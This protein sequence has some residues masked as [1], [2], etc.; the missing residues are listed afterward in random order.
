[1]SKKKLCYNRGCNQEYDPENN[2]EG[3]CWYHPGVP[4]FHDAYKGWSCCEKKSTDFT[5]FLNFKGCQSS[6]HSSEKPCMPSQ[7]DGQEDSEHF[8]LPPKKVEQ[9]ETRGPMY[10]PKERPSIEA[11]M[12]DVPRTIS[13]TLKDKLRIHGNKDSNSGRGD[14]EDVNEVSG[15]VAIGTQCYNKG[16]RES[17][18]PSTSS[19]C[20]FHPGYPVFHEGMK[21]WTCCHKRTSDFEAFLAQVGCESGNHLWTKPKISPGDI[22]KSK[23]CR[24]DWHQTDSHVYITVYSKLPFPQDSVVKMNEIKVSLYITF[25]DEKNQF[26]KVLVLYGIVNPS[27]S[28]VMFAPTKVELCLK[29]AEPIHWLDIEHKE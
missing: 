25:G 10:V 20:Q 26:E 15:N 12:I 28:Q 1:M 13:E 14:Y 9:D 27:C 22:D 6:K 11:P 7:I 23:T 18:G 4:V 3:S 8:L 19:L 5:D 16:C 29:K 21:F 24:F 2:P 17:Y